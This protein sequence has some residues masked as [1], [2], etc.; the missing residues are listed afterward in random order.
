MSDSSSKR[1]AV[2]WIHIG[3][4]PIC[5]DGLC[6]VRCGT[7]P[8]GIVR[9]YAMCDECE[10]TW[11]K[12]DILGP[13]QFPDSEDPLCPV[14]GQ[15]LYGPGSRWATPEDVRGTDWESEVVIDLP[16]D[17][18]SDGESGVF[19]TGEDQASALDVPPLASPSEKSQSKPADLHSDDWAY[20]QDEPRPGC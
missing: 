16:V 4:C 11:L 20:G 12:P 7:T 14:S 18:I 10:A 15:A 5:G 1:P 2:P 6:R 9:L 17:L 13:S 8:E 19:V 3:E